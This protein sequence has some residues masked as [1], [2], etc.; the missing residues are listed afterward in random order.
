MF[1]ATRLGNNTFCLQR[2]MIIIF[3]LWGVALAW[4]QN[5]T[6]AVSASSPVFA[7]DFNGGILDA[8]KWRSG[9][10]AGNKSA[11][12]DGALELRSQG[13]ESGWVI[14]RNAYAARNTIVQINMIKPNDDGALGIGPTYNL[15]SKFGVSDQKNW[16]R[17]YTYRNGHAGAY[18]L[19]V[20]WK[21]NGI[22]NGLDVTGNLAIN[23][24][25]YL[26][27]RFDNTHI[28]FETSLNGETWTDVYA[29]IFA[30]PGYTLD[31]AFF[32]EMSGYNTEGNGVLRVDDFSISSTVIPPDVEPPQISQVSAQNITSNSV[33]IKWQTSEPADAKVEYGLTASYGNTTALDPVLATSHAAALFGLQSNKAYHY[34]VKSSDAAGNLAVSG[35]FVFTTLAAPTPT[36]T[37]TS[38]NG[39]EW[40]FTGESREIK[41]NSAGSIA[42]VKLDYSRDGGVT[43]H[44]IAAST[45]NDGAHTWLVPDSM[46]NKNLIRIS[47]AANAG[48][49]D[50][51]NKTFFIIFSA[52]VKF[53]PAKSNP[54]LS[55]GPFGSWDERITERGWFMYENGMY[56]AWYGGWSGN[57]DHAVAN[58]VKLGYA[59]STDGV[60]WTKYAD[61]PIYDQHWT[62]DV[63]IV[64]NGN[65]YYMYAENEY[66]GDGDGATIDLYTSNDRINWTRYGKV[67]LAS[68]N[69]WESSQVGTATVWKEANKWYMLYEGFGSG[70][71]GKV[72]LA[73]SSDGKSWTRHAKNPVLANPFDSNLDIAIDSI[74]KSNGVYYAY[75]HYD[76]GVSNW[77]GGMFT[78]TDLIAWTAYPGNPIFDNSAVVVDNGSHYFFYGLGANPDA[79]APYYLQTS[80]YVPDIKPP[81]ISGVAVSH[82]GGISAKINWKTDEAADSQVEYGLTTGYGASSK[83]DPRQ[84]TTHAIALTGLQ[85]NTKYHYRLKSR[86]EAGNL[87]VSGNFTF[88]TSGNIF[89]DKFNTGALDPNK[90]RRGSNAGNQAAVA[91]NAL[92][93]AS[94]SRESGWVITKNAYAARNTRVKVKVV[95]PNND[96]ALGMSP[97]YDLSSKTGINGQKNWYRFYVYRGNDA[98]PYRLYVEWSKNG[99][100]DGREVTGNLA[101]NGSVYLRLRFDNGNILFEASLTGTGWTKA[102]SEAFALPGYTLDSK[103]Y[104][105]LSAYNTPVNGALTVDDFT[106]ISP[107]SDAAG[108]PELENL[109]ATPLPTAFVLQNFPNPFNAA[110]KIDFALPHAAEIE[111]SVF[112]L[113]GREIRQLTAGTRAAGNYQALWNGKNREGADLGSGVYFLRLRYRTDGNNA[114]SQMVRRIMMIK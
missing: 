31:S 14:T 11:V 16:Y 29:E 13:T 75:G 54:V 98:E 24:A 28:H 25:V 105:E 62:E 95:A 20:Q 70:S 66:A 10:N 51:S 85:P 50:A 42:N 59:Y 9:S 65:T 93:L 33:Q 19:F 1:M 34:R 100:T 30:L 53:T 109:A 2:Q 64:K 55:P 45:P 49:A 114:W 91:N 57:Y 72:G 61:H 8:N 103:F 12:I 79:L 58:F 18:R 52:L 35:D 88:T 71:A 110:T 94:A 15:S 60:N 92:K 7:D 23:G 32:Y 96:G 99:V 3:I 26:R 39:G 113:T 73:T 6:T 44:T 83:L 68:G 69:G 86:D 27:L 107:K 87:A 37:L 82:L 22:E 102:Y 48:V 17:F 78:S 67:L 97:T 41:W 5:R 106:I 81:V 40:W 74:V 63:V 4:P 43:W 76:T 21:K 47:N 111:L 89:S 46:S 101:I 36:L 112:D 104:Y 80:R 108:K 38:P 56:H 84:V 77:V 90:W